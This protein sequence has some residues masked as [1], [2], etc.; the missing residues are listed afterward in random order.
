MK[1]L[2]KKLVETAAPSGYE[3]KLREIIRSEIEAFVDEIRVDV[4]GNLIA[5]KQAKSEGK[6]IMIAAHIDEIGVMVTHIDEGGFAR[7]TNVGGVFPRNCVG[8]HVRFMNGVMGVIGMEREDNRQS[9]LPL[10]KM[11]IDSGATSRGSCQVKTGDVGVFE[12]PFLDLG[13]RLVSKAMDD[14]IGVA[15]IIEALRKLEH[16][17]YDVYFV[18]SAQEE[19]GTR[20]AIPA[21]YDIDP[22]LGLAVDVTLTGDTP[23][24]I[25]MDVGLGKGAAI[26][27]R[28]SGMLADPHIVEWMVSTAQKHN[29]PYQ[30][31][32]LEAGSTDARSIQVSRLGVPTGALSIPA[33]YVHTPSEMVDYQDVQAGVSL[34]LALLSNDYPFEYL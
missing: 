18:F 2:I 16:S 25:K 27:V 6:R 12:R 20:G 7:F 19:V 34:L 23:K 13:N 15:V 31:E 22:H 17:P 33:R 5:R 28:D 14:R 8:G 4:M 11:Y 32:V 3:K 26:K 1:S 24:S 29:I 21:A 10:E 30:L 9:V